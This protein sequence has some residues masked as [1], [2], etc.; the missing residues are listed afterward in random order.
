MLVEV[1]LEL[2]LPTL[3]LYLTAHEAVR[4]KPRVKKVWAHLEKGL[5]ALITR[6]TS[7]PTPKRRRAR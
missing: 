3:P 6:E 1:P 7:A 5:S 4:H 2:D